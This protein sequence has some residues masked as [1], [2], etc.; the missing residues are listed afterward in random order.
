M[1]TQRITLDNP[2]FAGR[3]RGY[4]R[5][6]AYG[7]ERRSPIVV[8]RRRPG[9]ASDIVTTG[10]PL[11]SAGRR[12]TVRPEL[13]AASP[14]L[15]SEQASVGRTVVQ[16]A[17]RRI[18]KKPRTGTLLI[19]MA[20]ALFVAGLGVVFVQ[21]RTNQQVAAQ[22]KHATY[23]A[24]N[25]SDSAAADAPPAET[26]PSHPGAY[27]VPPDQP[28]F[29]KIPKLSVDARV[30]KLGLKADGELRT[31]NTIFDTGWYQKSAKPGDAG[32]AIL[33]DGH[34]HGPTL[35]G[36]FYNLK[37][38]QP[39]D[40]IQLERGDGKTFEFKVVGSHAYPADTVDM[41]AALT[42]A[43][44]GKL[45]LNLITCTGSVNIHTDSYNQ[46]LI[47]FAVAE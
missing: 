17:A 6:S 26:K 32:G 35:P 29:L 44:P 34:V 14:V 18:I 19:A 47:V 27:A 46:R 42:S 20:A 37:K 25:S 10:S 2:I 40:T 8:P 15:P 22:V 38:L 3:L 7:Y 13:Q 31:P 1:S 33:I 41:A 23:A 43:V 30:L 5:R 39:G 16:P 9:T 12:Q 11:V 4:N 36:V 28:R 45:G 24:L 21:L